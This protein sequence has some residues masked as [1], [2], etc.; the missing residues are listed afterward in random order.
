MFCS[1]RFWHKHLLVR[2]IEKC[3]CFKK[4]KNTELKQKILSKDPR[5][6]PDKLVS[7]GPVKI[8]DM[9]KGQLD[10]SIKTLL[11]EIRTFENGRLSLSTDEYYGEQEAWLFSQEI[12]YRNHMLTKL[13]A[14][15][16]YH[17]IPE[18]QQARLESLAQ[19]CI[20]YANEYPRTY[21]QWIQPLISSLSEIEYDYIELRIHEETSWVS[22]T[23]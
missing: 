6:K 18:E 19:K 10:H 20:T 21:S 2:L 3:F 9:T 12:D 17:D 23:G 13:F 22:K 14:A 15:K 4:R 1:I 5:P 16:H 11:K 8:T 7:G